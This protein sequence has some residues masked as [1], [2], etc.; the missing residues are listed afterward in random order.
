[1]SLPAAWVDSLFARLAVTYGQRFM[2]LYAGLDADAV[3]AEWGRVLAGFQQNRAAL[4][5]GLENL[6]AENPPNA[7]QFR[8][9]CRRRP[10]AVLPRLAPPVNDPEARSQGIDALRYF[11]A[12]FGKTARDPRAWA[13]R[14]QDREE[15]GEHLTPFQRDAWRVALGQ[16]D[17]GPQ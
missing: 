3:K 15:S 16:V 14:L 12:N 10:A 2:G 5:Y 8:D 17:G 13:Y 4:S 7:L 11:A 9:I 1:M 6:P